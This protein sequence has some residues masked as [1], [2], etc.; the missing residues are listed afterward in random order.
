[1]L[2]ILLPLFQ[3]GDGLAGAESEPHLLPR[4]H[5]IGFDNCLKANLFRFGR[6]SN[7]TAIATTLEGFNYLCR[8]VLVSWFAPMSLAWFDPPGKIVQRFT[9]L[10]SGPL[11]PVRQPSAFGTVR[12]AD[13]RDAVQL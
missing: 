8:F 2:S 10:C 4:C 9:G 12:T 3:V 6:Q 1:M 7:L 13:R 11:W 5:Q